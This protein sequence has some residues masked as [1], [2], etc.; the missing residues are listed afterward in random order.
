MTDRHSTP[1]L[2]TDTFL[3]AAWAD[4]WEA[5]DEL[6]D[7]DIQSRLTNWAQR[8]RTQ[9][10]T[11]LEGSF[12]E[13][14]LAGV[15]GYWTTGGT[16][17]ASQPRCVGDWQPPSAIYTAHPQFPVPA[18]GQKGGTGSA[19]VA[20]GLFGD[21]KHQTQTR[22]GIDWNGVPQILG[23]FKDIRSGLDLPQN[24][25]DNDR[26]PVQQCF[27]YLKHAFDQTPVTEPLKPTWGLVTDMVEFRLYSRLHGQSRCQRFVIDDSDLLAKTPRGRRRRF[28]FRQTFRPGQLIARHGFSPLSR[29]LDGQLTQERSLEKTFYL[30]YKAYRQRVYEAIVEC[31]P[32]FPGSRGDL[33][34]LTQ[35]FL[36]R[37]LFVL[38]CEDMGR[39][40][41]FP[42][43][44]LQKL[45]AEQSTLSTYSSGMNTIWPV[46]SGLFET[47]R[48]GGD[49]PPDHTIGRFNGG[50]FASDERLDRLK[51]PNAVFCAVGQGANAKSLD[52]DKAT[53]LYL[54]ATYNFGESTSQDESVAAAGQL[55]DP[56]RTITLYT[57]GRI[58]E[59]SITELEYLHAQAENRDTPAKLAKRKRDGVYY[60]PEWVTT[61]IVQETVGRR[62]QDQRDRLGLQIGDDLPADQLK[63]Y[64][65]GG[66]AKTGKNSV[67]AVLDHL[68]RLDDYS[69]FVD[70][71]TVVDPACG[72]GAFL[73]TALS[74][75]RGHYRD[76]AE[77]RARVT[78][79]ADLFDQDAVIRGILS[80]NLYGVDINPESVEITQLALWLHT[81]TKGQPLTT[82]DHHIRCGNSLVG[83]DFAEF[84][85]NRHQ[86]LFDDLTRDE[87]ELV[88]VFD[89]QEAFPEI[90]GPDVPEDRRGFDC[91]VGNPPYVKLQ[92]MRKI[93][94][95]EVLYL[96]EQTRPNSGGQPLYRSTRTG[97]FDLYLPFI[98]RGLE[99]L[100]PAGR[101]GYIAPNVWL[102]N[103]YGQGLKELIAETGTLD[104]WVDFG[105]FQVFDDVTVYTALQFFCRQPT[106]RFAF[107]RVLGNELSELT[108][109]DKTERLPLEQ[110]AADSWLLM[111][112]VERQLF[113]RLKN[114]FPRLDAPEVTT[115][116][117]VGIQTSADAIYHLERQS[118]HVYLSYSTGDTHRIEDALMRPLVS[119]GDAKRYEKPNVTKF[120]LFPYDVSTN[121]PKL[122]TST[123]MQ[124]RFPNGW[125]YLLDHEK[126]LRRRENDKMD[127]DE[128]WWAYNYPKNLDKQELPK[129]GVA[130]TVPNLRLFA[131]FDGEF[132][133]NNVR[134]NAVLPASEGAI[135][136]LLAVLNSPIANWFFQFVGKPKDN[137]FFEANKQFIAP[138]PVPQPD[139][140]TQKSIGKVA[141]RLQELHTRRRDEIAAMRDRVASPQCVPDV[142]PVDWLWADTKTAVVRRDAPAGL[143]GREV[144]RWVRDETQRRLAVH[145]DPIDAILVPDADL[146][147][148]A[149]SGDLFVHLGTRP[150]ITRYGLA[151]DAEYLAALWRHKL[152]THRVTPGMDAKK[153][154]KLLLDLRT[155]DDPSLRT[156][157]IARDAALTEVEATIAKAE[158]EMND[159]IDRLYEITDAEKQLLIAHQA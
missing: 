122:F 27:D 150:L 104:R 39:A 87:Q 72:S 97:N 49:F 48:D 26:S 47:M 128:S 59:Q 101:M 13:S 137:G 90:F 15:L 10:E 22:S 43:K 62:L 50:L 81:A 75:L 132:F 86:T 3:L 111:S 23:E 92:H 46:V 56:A 106:D 29:L 68:Q 96:M 121:D 80:R 38:F 126:Q 105:H 99:L 73:I 44:L 18:A 89:W 52:N 11:Q 141:R 66:R 114:N 34:T 4:Q 112:S 19:D 65:S 110:K 147:V 17:A 6:T 157:L 91:V 74:F 45:L 103:E 2:F 153:L 131:D 5:Y 41:G 76:L 32:N 102:K 7:A 77:E 144:S 133:F 69:R 119:G 12:V 127:C 67:A 155:T 14:I 151:G 85:A 64:Q 148:T 31:N 35:R 8:D 51:I 146:T 154:I 130:Q 16:L 142:K 60:T 123:E 71:L 84:Y 117:T 20:L 9:T 158:A 107:H 149:D 33:V 152:R 134:V 109:D 30:Q 70:S 24:R 143:S 159:R 156:S 95:D 140:A 54:A 53:L 125:A 116:I 25:K 145:Y 36:D 139:L 40:V 83:P 1:P 124:L 88:N 120:L 136:Y 78:G 82:L 42:P 21:A 113:E 93:K 129:L 55:D 79:E 98:E 135:G 100:N 57:L 58:F 61:Y 118:D 37:C 94:E 108:W 138:I 63:R 115:G 28:L